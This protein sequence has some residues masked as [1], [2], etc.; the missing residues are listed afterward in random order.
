LELRDVELHRPDTSW[1]AVV[2]GAVICGIEKQNDFQS[3]FVTMEE[4]QRSYGLAVSEE[5]SAIKHLEPKDV[6]PSKLSQTYMAEEQMLWLIRKGDV[7]LSDL[8]REVSTPVAL[9]FDINDVHL[10]RGKMPIY[11]SSDERAPNRYRGARRGMYEAS[12]ERVV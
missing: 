10:R 3:Q 9:Q 4:C 7:L 6:A 8:P 11:G 1:T 5:Y 2:R 12:C